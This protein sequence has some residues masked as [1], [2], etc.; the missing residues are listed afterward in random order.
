[1]KDRILFTK[2][3]DGI[4]ITI[5][6]F[7]DTN[8]QKGLLAWIV[9]FSLCG[10]AILSQ[11]FYDYDKSSKLFFAL[12]L[13]FWFYFEFKV[14]Y[15]FRWRNSGV[16][17][18]LMNSKQ[19]IL[20][21]EIGKRGVTQYFDREKIKELQYF[22]SEANGFIKAMI[23]SYWN[24]NKYALAFSYDGVV[25]PFGIDLDKNQAKKILT[26]VDKLLK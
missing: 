21:K 20:I 15:A 11:F 14:I 6:A 23:S 3:N 17:R 22:E 5:K 10:I 1:M 25:V 18:I 9:L 19:L 4:E 16:E 26:E 24:I 7:K 13:A 2:N 8:K 12:Y